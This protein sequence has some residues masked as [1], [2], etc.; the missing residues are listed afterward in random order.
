MVSLRGDQQVWQFDPCIS[1]TMLQGFNCGLRCG[2]LHNLI[3]LCRSKYELQEFLKP[4]LRIASV[5]SGKSSLQSSF[6][7][8]LMDNFR[9]SNSQKLVNLCIFVWCLVVPSIMIKFKSLGRVGDKPCLANMQPFRLSI[10]LRGK[11]C[12]CCL[13]KQ[14]CF[15]L[16]DILSCIFCGVGYKFSSLVANDSII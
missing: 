13:I 9:S 8:K 6:S 5:S 2:H 12:F 3:F 7:R 15:S 4:S 11:W 16:V 1:G 10:R 14:H